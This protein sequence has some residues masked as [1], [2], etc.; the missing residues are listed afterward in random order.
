M[1]Y[2]VSEAACT[3][4]V[5]VRN[6]E[7]DNPRKSPFIYFPYMIHMTLPG[8]IEK[9]AGNNG[10]QQVSMAPQMKFQ[11]RYNGY[12]DKIGRDREGKTRRDNRLKVAW[13]DEEGVVLRKWLEWCTIMMSSHTMP[14]RASQAWLRSSEHDMQ[15]SLICTKPCTNGVV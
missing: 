10:T 7:Q 4:T 15:G 3:T 8:L 11:I 9:E 12:T 5:V 6:G 1:T 13:F 2:L 14:R